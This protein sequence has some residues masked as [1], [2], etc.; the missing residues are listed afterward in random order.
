V[1]VGAITHYVAV[2]VLLHWREKVSD[3]CGGAS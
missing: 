1:L 2:A 3:A